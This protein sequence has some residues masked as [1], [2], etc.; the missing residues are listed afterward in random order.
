MRTD[1]TLPIALTILLFSSGCVIH[2]DSDADRPRPSGGT[3]TTTTT[4]TTETHSPAPAP[5]PAPIPEF[6][7]MMSAVTSDVLEFDPGWETSWQAYTMQF[8][9]VADTNIC[10][11]DLAAV[12]PG[13]VVTIHLSGYEIE[14]EFAACPTGSYL[15][16]PDCDLWEGEAC[17][18]ILWRDLD[19]F[20]AGS[21]YASSGRIDI[22]LEAGHYGDPYVCHV[23]SRVSGHPD[24][25]FDF[26]MIYEPYELAPGDRYSGALCT[27]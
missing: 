27:M 4:T 22:S 18:E 10:S 2:A 5:A 1:L 8:S 15:V 24:M 7:P 6:V 21:D 25:S 12:A 11:P 14:D 23:S 3:T 26:S 19:G 20:E 17:V 16:A 13:S 9:D